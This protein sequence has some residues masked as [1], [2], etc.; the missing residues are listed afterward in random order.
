MP[1]LGQVQ[2]SLQNLAKAGGVHDKV[3]L[4]GG[5]QLKTDMPK[6]SWGR[7][8]VNP[9]TPEEK[10]TIHDQQKQEAV[11][12]IDRYSAKPLKARE[13]TVGQALLLL[14]PPASDKEF[15]E[16]VNSNQFE[17]ETD[18]GKMLF[19]RYLEQKTSKETKGTTD[20]IGKVNNLIAEISD[21]NETA[22]VLADQWL[23]GQK[24]KLLEDTPA[25]DKV[26][27]EIID[28]PAS[29]MSKPS[30]VGSRHFQRLRHALP[31]YLKKMD[32]VADIPISELNT[33]KKKLDERGMPPSDPI[34]QSTLAHISSASGQ[35]PEGNIKTII[36]SYQQY[37]N[38]I[39]KE[40]NE[41]SKSLTED[42]R[43]LEKFEEERDSMS[44]EELQEA[45][46]VGYVSLRI[47]DN[48]NKYKVLSECR[49]FMKAEIKRL[50]SGLS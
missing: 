45:L 39:K 4:S 17:F 5:D 48:E 36:E 8:L 13:V 26:V 33:L 34:Y 27:Q 7:R 49:N 16:C 3:R 10:A 44:D 38:L 41:V 2:Q 32:M 1:T 30:F 29:Q 35:N 37:Q 40:M 6:G 12:L 47:Q 23:L 25:C 31:E 19:E 24:I 28:T 20:A 43:K 9:L 22:R 18:V 15:L 21:R 42:K 11:D 14:Q 46:W 50:K